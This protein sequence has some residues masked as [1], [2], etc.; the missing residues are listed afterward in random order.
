MADQLKEAIN[1]AY[2]EPETSKYSNG[3]QTSYVLPLAFG[4][5]PEGGRVAL[6]EALTGRL[7]NRNRGAIATGLVGGQ[8]L[9]RSLSEVGRPDLAF[10][11]IARDEYPS[12]GYMA[13][14]G[15]TTIWELWNGNT[16]D[17]AM[18]SGNHVMLVGDMVTW[19]YEGLAGIAPDP[20]APGFKR[21]ILRP[22][23]VAGLGWARG[24][25]QSPCGMIESDWRRDGGE[26]R[27]RVLIPPSTTAEA[28][29]PTMAA[30]AVEVD[31]NP[32]TQ[33]DGVDIVEQRED[34]LVVELASGRYE[35]TM[36]DEAS[37][38]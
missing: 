6:G 17:P 27:W 38:D 11:L 32:L 10:G 20:S 7:A 12:W 15:A 37:L 36:P 22:Q 35:F 4:L 14:Q 28:H 1:A 26:L 2:Y 3:S 16:A 23:P 31:D 25:F 5:P 33:A 9:C 18:N 19:L 30:L 29:L 8:F 24:R 34:R 13:A 21:L